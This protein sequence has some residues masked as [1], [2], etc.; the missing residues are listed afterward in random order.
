MMKKFEVKLLKIKED[1]RDLKM[2]EQKVVLKNCFKIDD[3]KRETI[4]K[5]LENKD[6]K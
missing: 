1:S 6:Y 3:W 4:L 2:E 5:S